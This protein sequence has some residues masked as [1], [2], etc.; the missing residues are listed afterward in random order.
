M[1]SEGS[2]SALIPERGRGG[3]K[4]NPMVNSEYDLNTNINHVVIQ[5]TYKS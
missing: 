5:V 1:T 2:L 4:V 3:I